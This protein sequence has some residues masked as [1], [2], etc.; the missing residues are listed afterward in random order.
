M[1]ATGLYITQTDVEQRMTSELVLKIYDDD[2]TGALGTSEETALTN[3]ILDAENLVEEAIR[4]TYGEA[5]LVWLRAQATSAPRSVKR[6]CLDAVRL[7]IAERHPQYI[8]LELDKCWERF[9]RDLDR[10][11]LREVEM[12]VVG[13]PEP[14][15][16]DEG[17]V[18]SGNP[19]A[20]TPL[21]KVFLDGTGIY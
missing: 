3:I 14:A 13:S 9:Y 6:R 20:T 7:Y 11:K 12:A 18:R 4:K 2:G 16:T 8:R 10:L 15:V 17:T 5:G 1:P 21:P 19:D